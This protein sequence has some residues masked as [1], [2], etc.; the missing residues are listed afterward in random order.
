MA[1]P[2]FYCQDIVSF[3]C[4]RK[5]VGEW[6]KGEI[7]QHIRNIECINVQIDLSKKYNFQDHD[8]CF[9]VFPLRGGFGAGATLLLSF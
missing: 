3:F 8:P 5:E 2:C 7:T 9:V 6:V 4:F 1:I